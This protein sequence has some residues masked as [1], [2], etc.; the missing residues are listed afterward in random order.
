MPKTK[1]SVRNNKLS[2]Q[3]AYNK[4]YPI[5]GEKYAKYV[6]TLKWL[7]NII[8]GRKINPTFKNK[9]LPKN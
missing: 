6:P 9:R 5:I 3:E 4:L 7:K 1:E 2:A 8:N